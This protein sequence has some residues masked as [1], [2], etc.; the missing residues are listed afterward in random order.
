MESGRII[1][2]MEREYIY[3]KMGSNMRGIT[4]KAEKM[5]LGYIHGQMVVD[6]RATGVKV[7][8][9]VKVNFRLFRQSNLKPRSFISLC[10]GPWSAYASHHAN[11]KWDLIWFY[12]LIINC[13]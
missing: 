4:N 13:V 9:T 8:S 1:I 7:S 5:D 2:W 11:Y 6:T 3:G 12:C 10:L